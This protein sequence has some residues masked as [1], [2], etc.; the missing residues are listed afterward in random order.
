MDIIKGSPDDPFTMSDLRQRF[1]DQASA[2]LPEERL[3]TAADRIEALQEVEEIE[4]I[5]GLLG[6]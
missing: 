6:G 2:V 4:E 1:L 5:T 3:A